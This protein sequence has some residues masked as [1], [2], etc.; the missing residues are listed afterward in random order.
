MST[1]DLSDRLR[2]RAE[3]GEPRGASQVLAAA[4]A[5]QELAPEPATGLARRPRLL[6]VAAVALVAAAAG[7]ALVVSRQD[8]GG[9]AAASD[10]WCR[11]LSATASDAATIEG[12][13]AVYLE[14]TATVDAELDA[15]ADR[16]EADPRV[17]R[18]VVADQQAAFER[19][20]Q[21]FAGEETILENVQP[22]DLP[23]W[24]EIHLHDPTGAD[25]F[26]DELGDDPTIFEVRAQPGGARV[27]DLLAWPGTNPTVWRSPDVADRLG[28]YGPGWDELVA[29]VEAT[30]PP[31]VAPAVST[32]VARLAQAPAEVL[33]ADA[34][35]P[36]G[37]SFE[38][39]SAAATTL[40]SAAA[41]RCEL[42]V[43]D[44]FDV[45][46]QVGTTEP[47]GGD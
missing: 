19:F 22:D 10:P 3:R 31:E 5:A 28:A 27:L 18:I 13:V 17:E 37:P 29:E 47:P 25:A 44:R 12:D 24:V 39:A 9:P 6:A 34:E 43:D 33:P 26:I 38:A 42:E 23:P 11:A 32:L 46:H 45:R 35:A 15:Y 8:D 40:R 21:L 36:T 16:L 2:R 30:T 7:A 4:R 14:P 41:S 20:Q 1:T